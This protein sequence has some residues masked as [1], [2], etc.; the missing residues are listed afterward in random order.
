LRSLNGLSSEEFLS[1]VGESYVIKPIPEGE[2]FKP[3]SKFNSSLYLD[4]KWYSCTVKEDKIDK[5]N[6]VK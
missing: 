6:P 4:K 1:K 3:K 2:D 5:A